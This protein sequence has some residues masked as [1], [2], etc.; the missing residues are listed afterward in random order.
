MIMEEIR[1]VDRDWCPSIIVGW[2]SRYSVSDDD[3]LSDHLTINCGLCLTTSILG[4]L[5]ILKEEISYSSIFSGCQF[6]SEVILD[7]LSAF[8]TH[9]ITV[10][11]AIWWPF[12]DS[13]I[14]RTS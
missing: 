10:L 14:E 6:V 8:Q 4:C 13:M 2:E 5:M 1:I 7:L 9:V 11:T 12:A 3:S